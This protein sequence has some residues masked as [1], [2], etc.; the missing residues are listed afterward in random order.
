MTTNTV[1]RNVENVSSSRWQSLFTQ[2]SLLTGAV[3]FVVAVSVI[4]PLLALF[5]NSFLVLDD[6]GFDTEWGLGNYRDMFQG[7]VIQKAILNSVM[8]STGTMV[9]ATVLGVFLA[10]VNARTNCPGRDALETFNLIPFF[11]SPF[12]GAIAWHNLASPKVGLLNNL[13]REIF[14]IKG[15]ILNV[16]NIYGVIWVTAIFF[17]PLVYLFVIGSL[18]RMDPALE[19]CARTTGAGL[20]RTTFSVTLPLVTPAILSGA[21][22]VFVTSAG[23]FGVPFKLGAPYGWDTLTTQIFT[24]AVGDDA[25]H[26]MGS[27]MSM[28]LGVTTGF[29]IWI[30]RRI[31]APREFTT[32]TGKGFRPNIINLGRWKWPVFAFN[33]F[34]I[35]IAVFLPIISLI[36]V[37]LHRI[38]VGHII[39]SDLTIW[40][41]VKIL[42]FWAP[43]RFDTVTNGV[44]N[45]FIL[46][47]SGATIAMILAIVVSYMIHRTKGIGSTL[48]DFLSVLP[49]GFPGIVLAMGVLVTYIKTPIYATLWILLLGYITRFFP[50]GQR[51]V[52]AIMLAV[53]EELDQSSR[54][55]GAT[56]LTTLRRITIPLLKP[57]IFAGW[58]LL[59]VIFLRELSISIIL[60]TSGTETISVGVYYLLEFENDSLTSTLAIIQTVVLLICLVIFRRIA[61]R[62]ALT[63]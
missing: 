46:A 49:I 37:S 17:T 24:K 3:G 21:I 13:A 28:I 19:D 7:H 56:W 33:I 1:S 32:V 60:Y 42:H 47:F 8:I 41:Y 36:I 43:D 38:W 50:Y 6:L 45:S 53:S 27:A 26:Y 34:Y 12:V 44:I 9:M 51:N 23:E 54:M 18:R 30:Q 35:F 10:W 25:N 57:G 2:E 4:L 61:G 55:S 39:L 52:S 5:V 59:F 62:E 40:N 16:D 22:I 11:L 15:H 14:G 29:F 20:L 31:I 63:V 58:L 48:L